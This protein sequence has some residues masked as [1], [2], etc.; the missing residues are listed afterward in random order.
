MGIN[1][2]VQGVYILLIKSYLVIKPKVF[3]YLINIGDA[4]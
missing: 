1:N 4:G 2:I 3:L